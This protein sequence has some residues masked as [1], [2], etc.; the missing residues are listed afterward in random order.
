MFVFQYFELE[1]VVGLKVPGVSSLHHVEEDQLVLSH[2]QQHM[3]NES[4]FTPYYLLCPDWAPFYSHFQN[5][6]MVFKLWTFPSQ[7]TH[8]KIQPVHWTSLEVRH[9]VFVIPQSP[10]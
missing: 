6:E 3:S 2:T 7:S 9:Q 5:I 8:I 10:L 1:V 4:L